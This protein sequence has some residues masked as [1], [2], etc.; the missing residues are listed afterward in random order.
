MR[1]PGEKRRQKHSVNQP[2]RHRPPLTLPK[3]RHGD[4]QRLQNIQQRCQHYPPAEGIAGLDHALLPGRKARPARLCK[5]VRLRV[6][7]RDGQTVVTMMRQMGIPV[8][9]IGI[10]DRQ[11][12]RAKQLVKP[13]KT[14]GMPVDQL[15]LQGH[16]PGGKPDKQQRGGQQAERLP[17]RQRGKPASV[18][19]Q[20]QQPCGQLASPQKS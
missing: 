10:P 14:R 19:R 16:V 1:H 15:M 18:N 7:H 12:E 8:Q 3:G 6:I 13:G 9:A 11:R 17:E 20:D 2:H 5:I 4:P